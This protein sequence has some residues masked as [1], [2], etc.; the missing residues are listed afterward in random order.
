MEERG[1]KGR[2]LWENLSS[3]ILDVCLIEALRAHNK[4]KV[5]ELDIT[6]QPASAVVK[7]ILGVLQNRKCC[8]AGCVDWLGMLETQGISEEY[9]R[10]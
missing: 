4:K 1:Y 5:C 2:K 9:L 7:D 6:G 3:V 10:F 8:P